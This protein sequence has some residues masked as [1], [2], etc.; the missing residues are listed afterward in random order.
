MNNQNKVF[1]NQ[2]TFL[3]DLTLRQLFDKLRHDTRI[4]KARFRPGN[5]PGEAV[6]VL[7]TG[8]T[9]TKTLATLGGLDAR[10]H[11]VHEPRPLLYALSK[12]AYANFHA[13]T[14]L[15]IFKCAYWTAR[16]DLIGKTSQHKQRYLETSPQSTF[17]GPVIA[18]LI[19]EAKFIHLT[20]NPLS[21]I[22]SG[23]RRKWYSGH[24]MDSTRIEPLVGTPDYEAWQ[25]WSAFEKNIWLWRE[26]N[27][28]I[29]HFLNG[30]PSERFQTLCAENIFDN[31]PETLCMFFEF[32]GV[33][34][35]AGKKIKKV[36][37]RSM[38]AQKTGTFPLPEKWSE[39][40]LARARNLLG[41]SAHNLGYR[42]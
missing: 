34:T 19:P 14:N 8:R 26:T 22:R 17:L 12:S 15:E 6:F 29:R 11:A 23:M 33:P 5:V 36:L 1:G 27:Q 21:V 39:K 37:A 20:R 3:L 7:S 10:V 38:N 28:W 30:L 16:I 32:L 42:L 40:M 18:D 2:M 13:N 35:P 25:T 24:L 31:H 41:D 4:E 9:G